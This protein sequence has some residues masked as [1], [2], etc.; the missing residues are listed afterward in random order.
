MPISVNN[1]SEGGAG[2]L[3]GEH[4]AIS[5]SLFILMFNYG[6]GENNSPSPD[7]VAPNPE[8]FD[9]LSRSRGPK[10]SIKYLGHITEA[11]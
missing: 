4:M 11:K 7:K 5:D 9:T 8:P 3:K 10:G 2:L 6:N 1:K